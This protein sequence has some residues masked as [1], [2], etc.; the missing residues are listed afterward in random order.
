VTLA[1]FG[2]LTDENIDAEIVIFLRSRGFDVRD[3]KE[4]GLVGSDDLPLLQ[5][6]V[7]ENRMVLTHDSDFGTLA[8]LN[9]E[10]Y[11]GIVYLRPGH[12]KPAFTIGTLRTLLAQEQEV[13]PSFIIVAVRSGENVRIRIRQG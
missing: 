3:V 4:D 13:S 7:S 11:I 6:A 5:L 12:I 10:P 1:D 2:V 9:G 8:I